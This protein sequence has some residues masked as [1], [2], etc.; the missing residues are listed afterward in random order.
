MIGPSHKKRATE[1]SVALGR[2][3][4]RVVSNPRKTQQ[5]SRGDSNPRPMAENTD[6]YHH[7][8]LNAAPCAALGADARTADSSL[9]TV[10][11]AW[12]ELP[13]PV[14]RGILALVEAVEGQIG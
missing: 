5:W 9:N 13:E 14:K 3:L 2:V 10:L 7:S 8:E 4:A 12:A 1:Q 6:K 11:K